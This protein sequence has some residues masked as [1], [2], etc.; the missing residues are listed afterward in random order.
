MKR[1]VG[2]LAL[3][4]VL[5]PASVYAQ[6]WSGILAPSRATNWSA[7]GATISDR[8][9]NCVTAACNTLFGGTV[10]AASIQTA[11]ASAPANTV[12]RIPAGNFSLTA[13]SFTQSNITLR[14][15]GANQTKLTITN[16]SD[17]GLGAE[18]TAI[19]MIG[20]G[21]GVGCAASCGGTPPSQTATWT[22]SGGPVYP[23]GTTV[24]TFNNTAGL[25]AGPVGIGTLIFLD[26]T[27]DASDGYPALGDLV[28][29]E[30]TAGGCSEEGGNQWA[31]TGRSQ[32]QPVTVTAIN[33]SQVTVTPG[34]QM[35]NWR[36]SQSPGA[37]WI[38]AQ[39]KNSGIENFALDFSS[40]GAGGIFIKD[41]ANVWVKNLRL[42]KTNATGSRIWHVIPFQAAFFTV[43]DS[44]FYGPTSQANVQYAFTPNIAGQ[45]VFENNI[46]QRNTTPIAP[47]DPSHA[48]VYAYN[49]IRDT[50]YTGGIQP[51]NAGDLLS[52]YEGNN[53]NSINGENIHGPH[54]MSTHFRNL[55]DGFTN[56]G[57]SAITNCAMRI[58]SK[59]R[60]WNVIGNVIGH[61][62]FTTYQSLLTDNDDAIYCLGNTDDA[63]SVDDPHVQ[64]TLMR[65]GNWDSVTS[66]ND[67][68]TN[69]ATGTRFV[70]SEVPSGIVN[71]SNPV[72]ASQALPA[73]F[74]R[75]TQPP[76]WGTP[77]GT[78][79]WPPI[80]PDVS[81]GNAP[82]TVTSATGGHANK[83]PARLC[84]ENTAVDP[85]Y[86]SSNPRIL[87]FNGSTCYQAAAGGSLPSAPS[88]LTVQ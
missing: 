44:Y 48:G 21:E 37:W 41:A 69:D 43:R 7:A 88:D 74:Y 39:I 49:F 20:G 62:H 46:L 73:S 81:N 86:P 28:L 27:N 53:L 77:W 31:R 50:F 72:P 82:N 32:V 76:W 67:T 5:I 58:A 42:L 30:G 22:V 24:L 3:L 63:P 11:L 54:Y 51:H 18:A 45:F 80:G 26:Q 10:T 85:A 36:A 84:F 33:G 1:T 23:Q 13:F 6:P 17:A 65:W 83:I 25:V 19:R 70:A 8:T 55:H 75:A 68:G 66:T 34:L 2:V 64:R 14:G 4:L 59:N 29:C 38:S 35:P 56:N 60:F 12:V 57:Q 40:G 71:F 47:N 15:A 52:L 61:S 78:P 87:L 9:T 79:P 16:T